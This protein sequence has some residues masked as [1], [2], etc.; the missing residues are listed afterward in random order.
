MN[1]K[2][3]LFRND[4]VWQ[5]EELKSEQSFARIS[6]ETKTSKLRWLI[7]CG[8]HYARQK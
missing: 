3:T 6:R 1:L 2:G 5:E 4:R 7:E 8:H